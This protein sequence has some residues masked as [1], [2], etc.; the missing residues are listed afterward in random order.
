MPHFALFG[1]YR[2]FGYNSGSLYKRLDSDRLILAV[3]G[4]LRFI[5][6]RLRQHLLFLQA[7]S[8]LVPPISFP[9]ILHAA[10][11]F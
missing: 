3:P 7:V 1:Y 11:I 5:R 2:L 6:C 9:A 10:P 8:P 4:Q